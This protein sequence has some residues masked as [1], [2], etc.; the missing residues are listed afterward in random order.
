MCVNCVTSAEAVAMSSAALVTAGSSLW[1]RLTHPTPRAVRRRQAYEANARFLDS[2]GIDA[3][4]FLGPV[5]GDAPERR[6]EHA[7]V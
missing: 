3:Q 1:T 6:R 2:L 7:A 5:P 4:A